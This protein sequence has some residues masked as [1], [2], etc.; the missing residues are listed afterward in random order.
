MIYGIINDQPG[1]ETMNLILEYNRLQRQLNYLTF[2]A[3]SIFE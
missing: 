3:E 1:A 2:E